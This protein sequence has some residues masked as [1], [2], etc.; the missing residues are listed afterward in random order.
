MTIENTKACYVHLWR[1]LERTRR[2]L[3]EHHHRFT[4]RNVLKT[5]LNQ[6]AT[7]DFIWEVCHLAS[8]D[9]DEIIYGN[10]DLPEPALYPRRH[11]EVIRALV[12][13]MLGI[14][15]RHVSLR[16]L[17]AAYSIAFPYSTPININ[18]KKRKTNK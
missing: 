3:W 5:W 1:K 4:V 7:D 9:C 13:V 8:E 15:A 6:R 16:E 17:D 11:R 10:D 18:K 14:G 2:F 12:S